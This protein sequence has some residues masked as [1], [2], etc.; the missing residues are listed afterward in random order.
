MTSGKRG[1]KVAVA[2]PCYKVSKS[3]PGVVSAIPSGVR[4]IYCVDD[5]CP[6]N[7]TDTVAGLAEADE[8]I[9]IIRRAEN[10]G[11][12]AAVM[13]GYRQAMIDGMD[14]VVKIDGDG[15]M[16]PALID[17][18][19]TEIEQGRA[20]YTKGNRFHSLDMARSMP[21]VR[22][23]GNMGLSF[24]SKLST[25]YWQVFDPT[26]GYTAIHCNVLRAIN[27]DKVEE[28]YFF[29]SDLLF[30]LGL[31]RARV[32]EV[33][34]QAVYGDEVSSLS[35][36]DALRQ[37]P[38][39]H[40]RNFF[41]RIANDYF[42]RN[43][44]LASIEL[45]LGTAMVLFGLFFGLDAWAESS[46]SGQPATAGTVMLSALPLLVGVQLKLNFFAFDM[47]KEPREAIYPRLESRRAES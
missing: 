39:K 14:V 13:S 45:V 8:R 12:G 6:E 43:F 2:I 33:P 17:L 36:M 41:K 15:Q 40:A 46:R 3:L 20:D 21:L 47:A 31:V 19:V 29:E 24:F 4:K 38:F 22:K 10:G 30:H 18:F 1:L 11:V 5:A 25:G 42:L 7:S 37:F 44:S 32:V 28:R 34:M 9:C 27:L 23:I 16:D 26:N 35:N